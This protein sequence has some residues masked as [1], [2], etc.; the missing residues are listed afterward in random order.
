MKKRP[1]ILLITSDQHRFDSMGVNGHPCVRTPHLDAL[2]LAG[3]NFTNAY[4]TCPICMPARDTMITGQDAVTL[5]CPGNSPTFALEYPKAK[6]LGSLLHD[7]GYQTEL[8]GKTHFHGDPSDRMGFDHVTHTRELYKKR[9][10]HSGQVHSGTGLGGNEMSPTATKLPEELNQSHWCTEECL[11]FLDTRDKTQPFFLWASYEAPHPPNQIHEPYYSMY[12]GDE[13]PEPVMPTW[14]DDDRAPIF[15]YVTR[16]KTNPLPMNRQTIRKVR[17]VYYG[18]ITYMDHQI[19]RLIGRLVEQNELDNTV[20]V[21]TTDHGEKLGDLASFWKAS[22]VESSAHIPF[23]VQLPKWITPDPIRTSGALVSLEDLLPTIVELAG[24]DIP[25]GLVGRSLVPIT[26]GKTATIR[27]RIWGQYANAAHMIRSGAHKYIYYP[28]DGRELVFNIE[29]DPDELRDISDDLE[30]TAGLRDQL[31]D[32]LAAR[33]HP[34][35]VDGELLNRRKK[36][37]TREE[38]KAG[39]LNFMGLKRAGQGTDLI[40]FV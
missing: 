34:H 12:D 13:I 35:L 39:N 23:I 40:L 17:S 26:E 5:G 2:A 38:A 14:M 24:G 29:D 6:M 36:K 11:D 21:Y 33:E 22:F 18:M 7:A 9:I 3:T 8:V 37:P 4:S 28:D 19:G 31:R 1:N 25:E 27:D 32:V 10:M 20:I 30:L 16:Y 15:E